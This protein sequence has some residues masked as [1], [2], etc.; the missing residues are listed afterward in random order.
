VVVPGR[1]RCDVLFFVLS[2]QVA[3]AISVRTEL[4]E[5]LLCFVCPDW[6][7]LASLARYS[8]Q[9]PT[10]PNARC[11]NLSRRNKSERLGV[12]LEGERRD[13]RCGPTSP[14]LDN[15][16]EVER[17]PPELPLRHATAL[18]RHDPIPR[19]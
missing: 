16:E 12:N 5:H 11:K 8:S 17:E 3:L 4:G 10:S 15:R 1:L 14:R 9:H 6:A 18:P 7:D 13:E 2:S 19:S